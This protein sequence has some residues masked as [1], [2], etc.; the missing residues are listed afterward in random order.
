MKIV[1]LHSH[2]FRKIKNEY[3]SLGGLSDK[4]LGRYAQYA[5]EVTISKALK[6]RR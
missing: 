5:D 4:V 3:Y 6:G 2:K 1:F